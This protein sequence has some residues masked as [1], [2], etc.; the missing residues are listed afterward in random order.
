MRKP[1]I[2]R[3]L[4]HGTPVWLN[5]DTGRFYPVIAGAEEPPATDPP[6]TDPPT[7]PPATD[8]PKTDPPATDPPKA[9]PLGEPGKAAL[10]AERTARKAAEKAAREAQKKIDQLEAA[11]LSEADKLKKQ[12]ADGVAAAATATAKLQKANLIGALADKGLTGSK[13]KAAARLLDDVEYDDDDEPTNLD[14]VI[15]AAATEYGDDLFKGA[16]PKPKPPK[17]GGT[18]GGDP[19]DQPALTADELA[20]AKS[21]GMTAAEYQLFKDPNPKIPE[22]AKT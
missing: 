2:I 8:P 9:D 3:A 20:M 15:K 11:N 10:D 19:V 5:V 16:V 22:P 13:A 6:K 12:A 18:D 7:D 17:L 14:T 4:R 1:Q 21:F